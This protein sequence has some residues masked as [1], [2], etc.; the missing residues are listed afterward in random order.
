MKN[1]LIYI[2]VL[3]ALVLAAC[4]P[5]A[6]QAPAATEAPAAGGDM[7]SRCGDKSKLADKIYLYTWVEY[8]DPAIKDQF[9][10]ECGVEVIETNFD[11][12]ETLLATL[13]AGGIAY[14]IIVPS[15]YMV[16]VLIDEGMLVEL[17]YSVIPNI[18]NM[19]PLNVN[20]YFDPE[21]KYTVP[22]FWG[23]SGFAVDT[24]IVTEVTDSWSMMF[25][26]NSP[27]CGKISML[28]DQRETL[29][30]ALMYL[31]YPI[32]ETD[33]AH[34][35]EAKNLL[36]AQS[37]CVK[38]YDSQTNDDLIISGET[39]LA[40][41]WTGDAIL[42][43]LP[44]Y[45]GRE[46]IAYVIPQE[47]CTIWQDNMAVPV[48]APNP[49]T[50][51]IFMNYAQYPEIAAQDAEYVGYGTPNAAAKEYMDPEILA[52]EGIY[53]PPEVAARLQWIQDVGPALELYDRIWTEFKA[54]IGG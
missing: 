20:T 35:E 42:A 1:K 31:G 44:D 52:D 8:I 41:I 23:T 12:N 46:G 19:D 50:A 14:D 7:S 27:Y 26:P 40:H 32:N 47:G 22:W 33:P 54:S 11:S 49:Y 16:Q 38:A 21:Q 4:A 34:L 29:G 13:Q 39:V 43:G 18:K 15:D 5:A 17:D 28:D 6:T 10:E 9:K 25:D 45:G 24:N 2:F 53:P 48:G 3:L 51:M 36:I 30:A 37:K